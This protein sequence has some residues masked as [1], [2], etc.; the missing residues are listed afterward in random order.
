[1]K[2]QEMEETLNAKV[3]PDAFSILMSHRPEYLKLYEA[4][5]VD[6]VFSSHAHGRQFLFPL[7]GGLIGP[8]QGLFPL[9]TAGVHQIKS[10]SLEISRGIE[11]SLILIRFY[12]QP[13][14]VLIL[15]S[16]DPSFFQ[17]NVRQYS[18]FL[19]IFLATIFKSCYYLSPEIIKFISYSK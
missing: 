6:L 9:Y 4:Y 18:T 3:N 11:N 7:M 13:E 15:L 1:M 19:K 17:K 8:N 12:N 14:L 16:S 2:T 10:T 5:D